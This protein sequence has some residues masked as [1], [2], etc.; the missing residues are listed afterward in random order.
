M[1]KTQKRILV[2]CATGLQG[3]AVASRLLLKEDFSIRLLVRNPEKAEAL[4]RA[5]AE[6]FCGDLGE[7]SSLVSA[8]DGVDRVFLQ[9]PLD[10]TPAVVD[11]AIN[12]IDAAKEAGV[13]LLVLNTSVIVPSEKTG[14]KAIDLKYDIE[15]YLKRSSLPYIILRPTFYMENLAAPWSVPSIQEKSTVAYPIPADFPASWIGVED[16]ASYV[17]EALKKTELAGSEFNIGGPEVLTGKD[18]AERF[19]QALRREIDYYPIPLDTF[20]EQINAGIGEPIGTEIAA[21]YGWFVSQPQ[22]PVA[23]SLN[24]VLE[25]LPVQLTPMS[26]WINQQDCFK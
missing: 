14:V 3:Q 8:N 11:Y 15:H 20:E 1:N 25:K 5:G 2:Y 21:L 10:F 13:S 19:S 9:L 12:A 17:V 18:I 26:E 22:S 7:A 6:I 24:A 23:L 4:Q 16:L